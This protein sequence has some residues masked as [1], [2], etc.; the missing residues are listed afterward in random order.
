MAKRDV[1]EVPLSSEPPPGLVGFDPEDWRAIL[2]AADDSAFI[3]ALDAEAVA[4]CAR[5]RFRVRKAQKLVDELG[6]LVCD[7]AQAPK[8]FFN[9]HANLRAA[10]TQYATILD[11]LMLTPRTRS[12]SRQP[13]SDKAKTVAPG[14]VDPLAAMLAEEVADQAAKRRERG[15]V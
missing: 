6:E 1:A 15:L 13:I 3:R 14:V 9:V 4:A 10:E 2:A 8:W 5:A 11:K 12:H 7:L